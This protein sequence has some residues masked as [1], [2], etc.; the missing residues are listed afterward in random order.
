[1][2]LENII[3]VGI[4]LLAIF[5]FILSM[6]LGLPSD[7][8]VKQAA[9]PVQNLPENF[10]TDAN[11]LNTQLGALKVPSG[12]PVNVPTNSLGRSNVFESF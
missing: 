4:L 1:M 10:F 3:G 12:I 6:L 5:G 9:K 8:A 7:E 2:K 11:T